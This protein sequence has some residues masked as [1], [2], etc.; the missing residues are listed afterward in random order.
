MLGRHFLK[1]W[2]QLPTKVECCVSDIALEQK[3][4]GVERA[5]KPQ[6]CK[7]GEGGEFHFS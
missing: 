1:S 2:V 3:R 6:L 4:N 5:Q 7:T